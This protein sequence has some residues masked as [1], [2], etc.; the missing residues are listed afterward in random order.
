MLKNLSIVLVAVF[1][2]IVALSFVP[3]A[4][5][6]QTESVNGTIQIGN[7][8]RLG[9][10]MYVPVSYNGSGTVTMFTYAERPPKNVYIMTEKGI[11]SSRFEQF[12]QE[13]RA[14]EAQGLTVKL[15]GATK[16]LTDGI[17]I[18]ASGAMPTYVLDKLGRTNVTVVY[19]GKKDLVLS[20]STVKTRNWYDELAPEAQKRVIVYEETLD[21]FVEGGEDLVTPILMNVWNVREQREFRLDGENMAGTISMPLEKNA[22][23]TY[24]RIIY[25]FGTRGVVDSRP[26]ER[27][28]SPVES[29]YEVLPKERIDFRL[30]LNRTNGTAYLVVEK[31]GMELRREKQ[32][33][34]VDG[35][36]I[37][38][39]LSFDEPGDYLIKVEDNRGTVSGAVA[40][41][42]KVAI[43][44]EEK[45]ARTLVFGIAVDGAPVETL[46]APIS[47]DG[48]APDNVTINNGRLTL[49]TKLS[50]GMHTISINLF[51][52]NYDVPVEENAD[53]PLDIYVKYG[54]PGLALVAVIYVGATL[55]RRPTYMIR[56]GDAGEE[57]RKE[58]R[59][60]VKEALDIFRTTQQEL[61]ID[62]PV[63]AHEFIFALKKHY[64]EGADVTEGNGEEIL[65]E[66]KKK[67]HVEEAMGYYQ[68]AGA[69]QIRKNVMKRIISEKLIEKGIASR[70]RGD[71]FITQDYEVG[72]FGDTF[73]KKAII[74]FESESD[75][76]K[77]RAALDERERASYAIKEYNGAVEFVSLERLDEVL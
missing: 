29:Y 67:E 37:Y 12:V 36:V 43:T 5:A 1:L 31:D 61:G 21:E 2:F 4:S 55:S 63:R 11:G 69:G 27:Q 25:Q 64:T 39:V 40:H 72:F 24:A 51:G 71:K 16:A 8:S 35:G 9:D 32:N 76:K 26:L 65:R 70:M 7:I 58:M 46:Q 14:V 77:A 42:K 59:I 17:Y 33:R 75:L 62:G 60:S 23:R 73:S 13:I 22:N 6:P 20:G 28:I 57:I 44:L 48:G 47:L 52:T 15:V 30:E 66:L 38:Q 10:S 54:L 68:K 50:K 3:T 41:V 34:I 45:R 56:I 53:D 19:I 18:V 49:Y 74:V